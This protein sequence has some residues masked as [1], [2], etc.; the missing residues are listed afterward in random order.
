MYKE[1][2]EHF[3][4]ILKSQTARVEKMKNSPPEKDYSTLPKITVGIIEGDG[5]GPIITKQAYRVLQYLLKDKLENGRIE[6]RRIDGL[7]LEN[8]IAKG[9]TIPTDVLMQI[10]EC[11]V[12][13]KGPTTT[14]QKGGDI[15]NMESANVV[16]RRELDLFANVR[17]VKVEE[18]GID[19][20]FFRE[21]TEGEY[22]LGS[23][24]I[25]IGE[26]YSVDFK[27][28]TDK[29]TYRIAKAAFDFAKANGK[30]KVA[31]VTKANILKKTDGR[32]SE[33]C[34]KVAADYP[35]ITCEEWYVDI[36]SANLINNAI[37]SQ[38][39]VFILPNL[40]GDIITD[41]AAQ[42]QGGVGTAG[43]ANIGTQY[44]MFEAIHGSAP[45][46]I[47]QGVGEYANPSSILKAVEM[48][49]RHIHCI[50]EADSLCKAMKNCEENGD[51]TVTG[52]KNGDT[53]EA[54]TNYLIKTIDRLK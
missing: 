11:D 1:A 17:P 24:G 9:S 31:I 12:I 18:E 49:L 38:F 4:T 35:E 22:A 34:K 51:I 29:G 39:Q 36:M 26:D 47:E 7:T 45:R 33:I 14:P 48:L 41:E 42:I 20:T 46:M 13:L 3:E 28:T 44:A 37:R 5:I 23:C 52:D 15:P 40:Y 50:A 16:L 43:S 54:Y 8:R 10:K 19:W 53:T 21:N 25:D 6:L 30:N 32:F 27:V 2:L